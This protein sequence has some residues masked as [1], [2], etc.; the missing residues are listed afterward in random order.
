MPYSDPDDEQEL[1]EASGACAYC[2]RP[3]ADLA[4][5]PARRVQ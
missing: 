3:L 5:D 1:A 4:P 2:G